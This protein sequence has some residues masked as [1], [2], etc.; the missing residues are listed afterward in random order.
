[1]TVAPRSNSKDRKKEVPAGTQT[2]STNAG[3]SGTQ[4]L[5]SVE[6]IDPGNERE[7]YSDSSDEDLSGGA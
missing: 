5:V 3:S 6:H 4:N 2:N 1:M 7:I